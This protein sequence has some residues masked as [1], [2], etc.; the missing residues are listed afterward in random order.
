MLVPINAVGGIATW[1]RTF[2]KYADPQLCRYEMI[3]TS[4]HYHVLGKKRN[5]RSALLALLDAIK[6]LARLMQVVIKHKPHLVYLTCAPSIGLAV[7]D[8]VYMYILR[9]FGVPTIVHLHGGDTRGFFGGNIFRKW[10]VRSAL[11]NCSKIIAI[12]REVEEKAKSI[13]GVNHV[14]YLP[15][16]IDDIMFQR[17]IERNIEQHQDGRPIRLLH[18][19]RQTRAK[20]TMDLIEALRYV[21][22]PVRCELVGGAA[23]DNRRAIENRIRELGLA[24]SIQLVGEKTGQDLIDSFNHADIFVFPSH[25][26]GFPMVIL[27][28]MAHG[29][30]I[31]ATDVGNI[32]EM[33]G[34]TKDDT[35][36]GL[37]LKQIG[38]DDPKELAYLIDKLAL[39]VMLRKTF[40][41]NG[42]VRVRKYYLASTIVPELEQLLTNLC[43][44]NSSAALSGG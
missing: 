29:L 15:N 33:I 30:P 18:V 42:R 23:E 5:L 36:C 2:Q 38:S 43:N 34:L 27:E 31:I 40:S 3:D 13:F 17:Q 41:D 22:Q 20:G 21:S 39:D 37:L 14:I 28:A 8:S 6:R 19:G 25:G 12:T 16:M 10:I 32:R 44:S 1:A 35:P 26:E 7:R 4:V 9:L 11:K 24:R